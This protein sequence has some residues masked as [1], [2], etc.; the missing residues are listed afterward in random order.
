MPKL[1]LCLIL[2]AAVFPFA[3]RSVWAQGPA[4]MP[5]PASYEAELPGLRHQEALPVQTMTDVRTDR[6]FRS[7]HWQE[8][9]VLGAM[10]GGVF[11]GLMGH[12]L[13][14]FDESQRSCGGTAIKG[15]LLLA[16]P[17]GGLGALIG[18]LFPKPPPEDQEDYSA[19]NA[20]M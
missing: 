15:A 8:G 9:L 19:P 4:V 11:G 14:K 5:M 7:S 2:A 16:A 3:T 20:S 1:S 17:G 12:G 10:L 13:C 6:E 18:G